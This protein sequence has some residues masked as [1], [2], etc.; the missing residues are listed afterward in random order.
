MLSPVA[1][2]Q[3]KKYVPRRL[4]RPIAVS[5]GHRAGRNCRPEAGEP[6]P[7]VT[8]ARTNQGIGV[9]PGPSMVAESDRKGGARSRRCSLSKSSGIC[10]VL[11]L[12]DSKGKRAEICTLQ[13]PPVLE[14]AVGASMYAGSASRRVS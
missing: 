10:S 12:T 11:D 3:V 13:G 2:N 9:S 7:T 5:L 6:G 14:D 1:E 4:S 8:A